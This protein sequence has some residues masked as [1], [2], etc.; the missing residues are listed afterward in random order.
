MAFGQEPLAKVLSRLVVEALVQIGLT[1]D[2]VLSGPIEFTNLPWQVP[3]LVVEATLFGTPLSEYIDQAVYVQTEELAMLWADA[4]SE[5]KNNPDRV[6]TPE[7]YRG[8]IK[9]I[10]SIKLRD[11]PM[12]LSVPEGY[13]GGI[14]DLAATMLS[15][16]CAHIMRA[17]SKLGSFVS[18]EDSYYAVLETGMEIGIKNGLPCAYSDIWDM[19]SDGMVQEMLCMP[20]GTIFEGCDYDIVS[21]V[22]SIAYTYHGALRDYEA[23]EWALQTLR[24]VDGHKELLEAVYNIKKV[25]HNRKVRMTSLRDALQVVNQLSLTD[26]QRIETLKHVLVPQV[27]TAQ[28]F[29][30]AIFPFSKLPPPLLAEKVL[31]RIRSAVA[32]LLLQEESLYAVGTKPKR[33]V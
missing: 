14:T 8:T 17:N 33:S 13:P 11:R 32:E 7:G 23:L 24:I 1:Q 15:L 18:D 31:N 9:A 10:P 29:G 25:A 3:P 28:E 21:K 26:R 22:R 12:Y 2:D 27:L 5:M 19:P 30:R 6:L 16:E 4:L 20:R